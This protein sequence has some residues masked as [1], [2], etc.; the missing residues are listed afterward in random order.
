MFFRTSPRSKAHRIALALCAALLI[1]GT[2]FVGSA[3]GF[4]LFG[5]RVIDGWNAGELAVLASLR[6][7][8]LPAA[9]G[10]PSSAYENLAAAVALGQRLFDDK[11]FSCNQAVSCTSCHDPDRQFQD[12]RALGKGM[13]PGLRR[14]MPIVAAGYSPKLFW[15]GRKD[16]VWSQALGP[17]EDA[18]E[19]GGNRVR[20]ARLIQAH[21]AQA[22]RELFG[23][24]PDFSDLPQDASPLGTAAE[25][26]EWQAMDEARRDSVSRAFANMG[27]AIA[28][29]EKTLHHEKS[30]LDA[31]LDEAV[32]GNPA[33]LHTLDAREVNGLRWFIV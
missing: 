27:K 12:G 6:L 9:P 32:N 4:T 19:H 1:A 10:D 28:A 18:A 23:P 33:G 17:L 3:R 22:Y 24:L 2:L 21:Y 20:Y 8:Q 16:S 7:S 14:S 29:Y 25:K 15:D 11:R 30:R 13:G 26:A 5:P 31:Y